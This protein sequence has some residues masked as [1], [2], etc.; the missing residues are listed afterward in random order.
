MPDQ[1]RTKVFVSNKSFHNFSDAERFGELVYLTDGQVN[2]F[3]VNQLSRQIHEALADA[4]E[5][6]WL[7]V[8]SLSV[9]NS[10]ASAFLARRFSQLNMLIYDIKTRKY[11]SRTVMF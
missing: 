2:R 3:E 11:V 7:L 6:D 10:I 5:H 8:T 9:I 4:Q 1:R